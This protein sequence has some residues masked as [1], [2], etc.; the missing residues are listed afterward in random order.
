MITLT[1][2]DLHNRTILVSNIPTDF[3]RTG[4]RQIQMTLGYVYNN[5]DDADMCGKAVALDNHVIPAIYGAFECVKQLEAIC[6]QLEHAGM[7]VPP[8]VR[9]ALHQAEGKGKH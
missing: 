3:K 8:A 7:N 1:P 9:K 2:T 4:R 6:V 5:T